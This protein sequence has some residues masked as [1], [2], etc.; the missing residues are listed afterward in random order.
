MQNEILDKKHGKRQQKSP[1][2]HKPGLYNV[3]IIK[4]IS[5]I[6]YKFLC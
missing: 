6:I 1:D 4:P 5:T 2:F 3:R